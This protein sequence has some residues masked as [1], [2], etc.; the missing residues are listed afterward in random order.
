MSLK[1][2]YLNGASGLQNQ[3]DLAYAAGVTFISSQLAALTTQLQ[4][5]AAAGKVKF[6]ITLPTSYQPAYL[7]AGGLLLK[8]YLAGVAAGLADEQVY[9]YECVPA[10][11]T[12][13]TLTTSIDLNFN[14]QTV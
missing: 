12:T 6:T 11:N 1:T 2:D 14:F 3:L 7:R 13:D 5:A 8:A 10:L 9:N 4:S